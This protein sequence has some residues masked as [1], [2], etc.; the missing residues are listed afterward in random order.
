[1]DPDLTVNPAAADS[2]RVVYMDRYPF[3]IEGRPAPCRFEGP[4]ITDWVEMVLTAPGAYQ[5]PADFPFDWVADSGWERFGIPA[6]TMEG[7]GWNY[8]GRSHW[9]AIGFEAAVLDEETETELVTPGRW[10]AD[11]TINQVIMT[12][13]HD[14]DGNPFHIN[15]APGGNKFNPLGG[16][17]PNDGLLGSMSQIKARYYRPEGA[18]CVIKEDESQRWERAVPTL[19][20]IVNTSYTVDT[21]PAG[22]Q[23]PAA[24]PTHYPDEIG[25]AIFP[26]GGPFYPEGFAEND[27]IYFAPPYIDMRHVKK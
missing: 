3:T 18:D 14:G 21:L 27:N 8:L 13:A 10:F 9:V 2:T 26:Y 7:Y 15:Y 6:P 16:G 5:T 12:Y 19:P 17:A 11:L 20:K 4:P 23:W 24:I 1:M 25:G 22:Y